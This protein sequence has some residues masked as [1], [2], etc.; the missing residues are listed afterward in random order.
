MVSKGESSKASLGRLQLA[1]F[2]SSKQEVADSKQ[3]PS[4][5]HH[6]KTGFIQ[7]SPAREG[8]WTTV[9]L[10][11][12]APV[13]CWRL[14]NAVVASEVS[15]KDGNR[16][17]NVRSLVSVHNETDFTLDVC[18]KAKALSEAKMVLNDK[19]TS[20]KSETNN[21]RIDKVEFFEIEKFVPDVGWVCC[22]GRPSNNESA[23]GVLN[24]VSYFTVA[25]VAWRLCMN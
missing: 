9:R 14:G 6:K 1:V 13:A 21:G 15:V 3:H 8:P 4:S 20:G 7:I 18:L 10:N 24:E 16:Y 23:D 19:V 11:Y 5:S 22:S 2:L 12:A 17:V 25:L